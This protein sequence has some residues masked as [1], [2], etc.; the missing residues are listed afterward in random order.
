MYNAQACS[1][2]LTQSQGTHEER[3]LIFCIQT[4][5]QPTI[6]PNAQTKD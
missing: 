5:E 4:H 2:S 1:G 6:P 3:N